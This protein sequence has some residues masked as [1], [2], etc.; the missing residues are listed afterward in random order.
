MNTKECIKNMF[1]DKCVYCLVEIFTKSHLIRNIF[2]KSWVVIQLSVISADNI[3]FRT[4][5]VAAILARIIWDDGRLRKYDI[6][7]YPR[8]ARCRD[9]DGHLPDE[10][11]KKYLIIGE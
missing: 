1:F 5:I 10:S 4:R 8:K 9:A 11:N 2:T 7:F 3:N 6:A